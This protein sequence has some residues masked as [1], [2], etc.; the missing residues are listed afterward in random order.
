LLLSSPLSAAA[1]PCSFC[2]DGFDGPATLSGSHVLW[3]PVDSVSACPAA[4]S[5]FGGHPTHPHPSRLRIDVWYDDAN[6]DPKPDVPPESLWVTYSTLSGNLVVNDEGPRVFADDSTDACGRTRITIPSFSGCGKLRVTLWISGISQGARDFTIRSTDMDADGRTTAADSSSPS[7][8]DLDYNGTIDALDL[9]LVLAHAE[10][11]HRHALHGTLVRRTNLRD[12][13]SGIENNVIGEGGIFW[14]PNGRRIAFS[15]RDTCPGCSPGFN[16]CRIKYVF[17][18]PVLG[19]TVRNLTFNGAPGDSA[20][21]D[22]MDYNPS[23]SPL[24]GYVYYDRHDRVIHRKGVPGLNSDTSDVAIIGGTEEKTEAQISP[25][26]DS[27]AYVRESGAK[28]HIFIAP[29]TGGSNR[30]LT[31]GYGASWR[32]PHWSPDGA[33]L[34]VTREDSASLQSV[35]YKINVRGAP[36]PTRFFPPQGDNSTD[37]RWSAVSPDSEVVV[38]GVGPNRQ[39]AHTAHTVEGAV[40]TTA[41]A[42]ENY[43]A[44]T[45]FALYPRLSPDGTR[46][47]LLAKDPD[48]AGAT[49][50]QIWAVRRNMNTPPQITQV[51]TQTVADST[52]VVAISAKQGLETNVEI[53]A[54][55]AESDPITCR[56]SFLQDGM[57][58]NPT[59]C[60]LTWTPSAPV[61]TKFHVV[62][63][64]ATTTWPNG[65][66]GSDVIIGEF[67]VTDPLLAP[68]AGS[69]RASAEAADEAGGPNPTH[70]TFALRTPFVA[71]TVAELA[72][73]DLSGRRVAVVRGPAGSR[74]VWSGEAR[75]G[76]HVP[77]GVYLYRLT[78]GD[79]HKAGRVVYVR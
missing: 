46:L 51:G 72:V 67:T 57:T 1:E 35:L 24:G 16:P 71:G 61:G 77:S 5:V 37:A 74:L 27:L 14:S 58:F 66:G 7:P 79:Y 50:P 11:W 36:D 59:T 48:L 75:G 64:V 69:L 3:L 2:I 73:F 34:T 10:H 31:T 12:S 15:A 17:A 6:C 55:D 43:P 65:S 38:A 70:G 30:R 13:G 8:C 42:I 41:V 76:T 52:V 29:A 47:A 26:G 28:L 4:D 68:G 60:T 21:G 78:V 20:P 54:T 49:L 18:D 23:W 33:Y 44:H 25:D 45:W 39:S 32:D 56:A 9:S 63:R 40:A 19:N 62:F 53:V 22:S